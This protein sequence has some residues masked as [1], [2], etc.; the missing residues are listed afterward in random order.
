MFAASEKLF[1]EWAEENEMHS[2]PQTVTIS[3]ET[4]KKDCNDITDTIYFSVTLKNWGNKCLT[5]TLKEL[6]SVIFSY[7]HTIA[8][9]GSQHHSH[10]EKCNCQTCTGKLQYQCV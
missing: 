1:H 7:S 3:V 8:Q 4:G 10:K 5:H 2:E 9:K 6:F